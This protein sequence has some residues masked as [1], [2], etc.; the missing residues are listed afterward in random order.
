MQN[1]H[2]V[3]FVTVYLTDNVY[4]TKKEMH[5]VAFSNFLENYN[6]FSYFIYTIFSV[7]IEQCTSIL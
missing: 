7:L 2:I 1:C 4:P 6:T 5:T 3:C